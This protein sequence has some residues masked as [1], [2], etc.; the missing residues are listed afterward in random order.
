M[1]LISEIKEHARGFFISKPQ[2][3]KKGV[4]LLWKRKTA[5]QNTSSLNILQFP[6]KVLLTSE[7]KI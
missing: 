1:K 5:R 3:G 2:A 7:T 6:H 4:P